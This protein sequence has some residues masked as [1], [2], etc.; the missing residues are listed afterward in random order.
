MGRGHPLPPSPGQTQQ[1]I[2]GVG[3][4]SL[5]GGARDF[6]S[7]SHHVVEQDTALPALPAPALTVPQ[8]AP[9]L[10]HLEPS[11]AG[12]PEGRSCRICQVAPCLGPS[13]PSSLQA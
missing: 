9:A 11:E 12:S 1:L 4:E 2:W 6:L 10:G 5:S 13:A 3:A 7:G 8:E